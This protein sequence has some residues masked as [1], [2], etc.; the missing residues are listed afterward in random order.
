MPQ[1]P[2]HVVHP[3]FGEAAVVRLDDDVT[4]DPDTLDTAPPAPSPD[5]DAADDGSGQ[6][7]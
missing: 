1:R 6:S 3:E 5:D 7:S 2:T 4:I